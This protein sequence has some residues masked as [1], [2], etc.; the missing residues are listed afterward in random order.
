MPAPMGAAAVRGQ[1]R[2]GNGVRVPSTAVGGAGIL[3]CR[4]S[5]TPF[6]LTLGA[7]E[8][9]ADLPSPGNLRLSANGILPRFIVTR[10][11]MITGVSSRARCPYPFGLIRHALLPLHLREARCFGSTLSPVHYRRRTPRPVSYYALFKW[12]LL[13]SQHPGCLRSP[14]SFRTERA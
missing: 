3:T 1:A 10:S 9:W 5:A 12:W 4:P 13:L 2:P 7:D 14:T 8:P 6:V 11:G